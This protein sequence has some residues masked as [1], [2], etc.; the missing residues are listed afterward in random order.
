MTILPRSV[1]Q[2]VYLA[3]L[4]VTPAMAA[5]DKNSEH[6]TTTFRIYKTI[7]EMDSSKNSGG[8]TKVANYLAS[9][10][11]RAGFSEQDVEVIPVA[12]TSALVVKYRGKA[13][14]S[15][16]PILFLGHMDVVEA[17]AKD[18]ERPPFTLT[19]DKGYFFGRGTLDNK[20]GI[21][22]IS[23]T[24][25]ALKKAGYVPDRDLIIAFSGDEESGMQSTRYLARRPD[26]L[27]AAYAIN[28]DA[29]GGVLTDDASAVVYR[30][31][32]AEKTYVTFEVEVKNPGGH[33]SRPR[34]DNAIY[35]L[36]DALKAVQALRF[37]VM[38]TPMTLNYLQQTGQL[39]GGSTGKALMT[40]ANNPQD[41]AA[42]DTLFSMPEYV[43][44]TRTTCVATM[45]GGGHA[46]NALPQSAKATVNCRVF[47]GSE[48]QEVKATLQKAIA[49][50]NVSITTLTDYIESPV[51][52]LSDDVLKAITQAVEKRYP[53]VPVMPYME[54]GGTDGMHFRNAGIPT[55]GVSSIFLNPKDM[56]AHGLNER[57]P[58]DGFYDSMTHWTTIIK[59]LA[60][61]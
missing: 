10:F 6:A 50:D 39:T 47:P 26:L 55:W 2:L 61:Q 46:E 18:W 57:V 44:T 24:F 23:G 36:A 9:E 37:P 11:S 41:K 5:V 20:F 21:A 58:V 45:L 16:S 30:V 14:S 29:G 8:A 17:L 40:F 27:K 28:T 51:S 42:A 59:S 43:G 4:I 7:V 34:L 3:A 54:S 22:Q 25:I 52:E 49:N 31:Q 15:H 48:V 35:E 12:Q 13:D 1:I 38:H 32:A 19:Q 33:S 53:N 56:F 60:G